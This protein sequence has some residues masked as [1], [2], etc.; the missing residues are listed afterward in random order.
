MRAIVFSAA[1]LSMAVLGCDQRQSDAGEGP[2]LLVVLAPG[3][4]LP[5]VLAGGLV[6]VPAP[7]LEPAGI[8]LLSAP[9]AEAAAAGVERVALMPGVA[10]VEPDSEWRLI[11]PVAVGP[12]AA[13]P[14]V[15]ADA[16]ALDP[17]VPS[18]YQHG[19]VRSPDAWARAVTGGGAVIAIVDTGIDCAHPDLDCLPGRDFTGSGG[20][21]D[22]HGHGTHVAGIAGARGGNAI[23]GSGI[24]IQSRVVPVR[25]L[26]ASG[27]GSM[28]SIASGIVWAADAGAHVINLSL[29]GPAPSAALEAAVEYARR[30]GA[31]V[32]CAAGNAGSASPLYPAALP[33]CVGVGATDGQD[34]ATRWSSYGI[35][36]QVAAPGDDILS[37][38]RGGGHC[39]MS[40]TSMAAPVWAGA[41]ALGRARGLSRAQVE[42]DLRVLGDPVTGTL[43]GL[44]RPN[45]DLTSWHWAGAP[46]PTPRPTERPTA[47][48]VTSTPAPSYPGPAPTPCIGTALRFDVGDG[49]AA[50]PFIGP[51]LVPCP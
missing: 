28:S 22:G 46:G 41:A 38:C 32:V 4:S 27:S 43:A 42:S 3:A 35:N 11:E 50:A 47:V 8:L 15:G 39:R 40:G 31:V 23:G 16:L 18:Q 37:T 17:L 36:A 48:I 45:L 25:V 6:R 29:G 9:D 1:L 13:S 5:D 30:A 19:L 7:V 2:D 21:H 49:G 20:A 12:P 24:A 10:S 44:R 34:V 33:G 26:A 14:R 51:V